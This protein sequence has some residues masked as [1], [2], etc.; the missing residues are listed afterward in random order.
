M[1][2][3]GFQQPQVNNTGS[4]LMMAA[5]MTGLGY[6]AYTSM[7]MKKNMGSY[8]MKGETFMSPLVQQRV[9]KTL[10]YFGYG[11]GATGGIVFALRNSMRAAGAN[12]WL[13]LGGSI[14]SLIATHMID[15]ETQ[16]PLK[17]LAYT[18]FIGCTAL[19]I[20][21]LIQMSAASV[22]ADAALAT[23]VTMSTLATIAYNAPSEQFLMWGGALGIGC[24][25]MMGVS[26]LSM[27]VPG[28]KALFNVWLYGG[29]VLSGGLVLYRTQSIIHDAKTVQNYDPVTK[30]VGI[31]LDAINM[32]IR[33][34]MIMQD[35]K[36]K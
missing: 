2:S 30:S 27:M 22:I 23:G 25:A 21:P 24:G 28:S 5:G 20:L 32:F 16:Y 15:Y 29:L 7:D 35:N 33:F 31:Y 6:L 34:L 12:P 19:S 11:I 10:G 17:M 13:L 4:Y 36:K 1:F 18:G 26:L 8:Q 14:A 9:G 3:N